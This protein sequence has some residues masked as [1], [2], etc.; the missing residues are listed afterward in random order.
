[1]R[2]LD[3]VE[4]VPL[5]S[6]K[7]QAKPVQAQKRLKS[8]Y[9]KI[10]ISANF[11]HN[12]YDYFRCNWPSRTYVFFVCLDNTD[13]LNRIAHLDD[14]Q[15][16]KQRPQFTQ[17]AKRAFKRTYQSFGKENLDSAIPGS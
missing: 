14:K 9:Q 16:G 11:K 6:L 12:H 10:K 8:S 7:P 5:P 4:V 1:M 13:N 3:L 15:L 17:R 2:I